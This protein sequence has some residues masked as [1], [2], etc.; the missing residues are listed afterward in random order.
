MSFVEPPPA[1]NPHNYFPSSIELTAT[2]VFLSNCGR[3]VSGYLDA[4]RVYAFERNF[5]SLTLSIDDPSPGT[6]HFFGGVNNFPASL[7]ENLLCIGSELFVGAPGSSS[8]QGIVYVFDTD[9]STPKRSIVNPFPGVVTNFGSNLALFNGNLLVWK[10]S[11]GK[12]L[13]VNP[14]TGN[15]IRTFNDPRPGTTQFPF[16]VATLGNTVY[17][18]AGRAAGRACVHAFN[19]STGQLMGTIEDPG[20]DGLAAANMNGGLVAIGNSVY[21]GFPD[22]MVMGSVS[23]IKVGKIYKFAGYVTSAG[24]DANWTLY[25]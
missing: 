5:G 10:V 1:Y 8:G 3:I 13:L 21:V 19:G 24:S 20:I 25:D 6:G 17:I 16:R 14:Q 11:G 9:T 18:S 4:G 12:V 2:R 23:V 15:H 7:S 22:Y